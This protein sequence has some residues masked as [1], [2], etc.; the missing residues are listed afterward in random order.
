MNTQQDKPSGIKKGFIFALFIVVFLVSL[1]VNTPASL[2]LKNTMVEKAMAQQGLELKNP[3][4]SIWDGQ[5]ELFLQQNNNPSIGQ[6]HW[7]LNPWQ[8]F[9]LKIDADT[10]W[11]YKTSTVAGNLVVKMLSPQKLRANDFKGQLLLPDVLELAKTQ[12]PSAMQMMQ[13]AQGRIDIISLNGAFD[14][15]NNSPIELQTKAEVVNFEL[16]ENKLPTIEIKAQ[17]IEKEPLNIVLLSEAEKWNLQGEFTSQDWLRYRGELNLKASS[18]NDL[19]EWAYALQKKTPT[20]YFL[21]L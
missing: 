21:R 18:A 16:L 15:A 6:V 1:A 7:Q 9:L 8:L 2:V 3:Q 10:Q 4:G 20:H 5:V 13:S 19:P 11:H 14:I 17:Q 12:I